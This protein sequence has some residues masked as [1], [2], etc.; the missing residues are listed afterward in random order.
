[1]KNVIFLC[2]VFAIFSFGLLASSEAMAVTICDDTTCYVYQMDYDNDGNLFRQL[3][4]TYPCG[5]SS[6]NQ[7]Y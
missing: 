6:C 4:N 1:M 2:S 3:V 7:V 5:P